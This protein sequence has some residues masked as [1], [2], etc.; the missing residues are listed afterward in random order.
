MLKNLTVRPYMIA[1]SGITVLSLPRDAKILGVM[2]SNTND[3]LLHVLINLDV[4]HFEE[5][6]FYSAPSCVTFTEKVELLK[7]IGSVYM[8]S[9]SGGFHVFEVL[10]Y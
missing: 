6:E 7:Y 1:L 3:V 8:H 9:G 4:K 5:R 10:K 2:C